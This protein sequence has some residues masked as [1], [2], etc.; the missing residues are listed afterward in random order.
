MDTKQ[1]EECKYNPKSLQTYLNY[2]V[3]KQDL[4]FFQKIKDPF[5][6][7]SIVLPVTSKEDLPSSLEPFSGQ[8][9]CEDAGRCNLNWVTHAQISALSPAFSQRTIVWKEQ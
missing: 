9:K 1:E 7:F 4:N 3:V 5:E 8:G 2:K 6:L